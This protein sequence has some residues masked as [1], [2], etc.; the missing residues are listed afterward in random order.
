MQGLIDTNSI[1]W[2]QA[3]ISKTPKLSLQ[4][5]NKDIRARGGDNIQK[6]VCDLSR[7]CV[8]ED[9]VVEWYDSRYF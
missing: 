1:C 8:V 7:F 3:I 5:Y 4:N 9:A 2:E 6:I